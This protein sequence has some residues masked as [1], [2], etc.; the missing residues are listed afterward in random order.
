MEDVPPVELNGLH[1]RVKA[2]VVSAVSRLRG[3]ATDGDLHRMFEKLCAAVSGPYPARP[4]TLSELL[5]GVDRCRAVQATDNDAYDSERLILLYAVQR[6]M[7]QRLEKHLTSSLQL[8][9]LHQWMQIVDPP[10]RSQELFKRGSPTFDAACE[11]VFLQRMPAGQLSWVR[12]GLP[13]STVVGLDLR[14]A[15]RLLWNVGIKMHGFRPAY[16]THANGF[17]RNRFIMQEQEAR[18]SYLRMAD[19]MRSDETVLGIVT[20]SWYHDPDLPSISPHLRWMNE[21]ISEGG[22]VILRGKF[23]GSDAGSSENSEGRRAAAET[24][25]YQPRDGIV[26]WPRR[27]VLAW[28]GGQA[29]LNDDTATATRVLDLVAKVEATAASSTKSRAHQDT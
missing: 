3:A 19:A 20:I 24:G 5:A 25:E 18:R 14:D 27:S 28:A 9:L 13:R 26:L 16:F 23:S 11:T 12:S 6:L 2:Q 17:R 7:E 4:I 22:G 8:H 21:I 29:H 10:K 1:Q 15:G